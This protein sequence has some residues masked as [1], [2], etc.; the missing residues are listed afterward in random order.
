MVI[1]Q[2]IQLMTRVLIT[3]EL[4]DNYEDIFDNLINTTGLLDKLPERL[5]LAKQ[6][7]GFKET[8]R[9]MITTVVNKCQDVNRTLGHLIGS[10]LSL[11]RR[12]TLVMRDMPLP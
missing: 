10:L 3:D 9:G 8:P 6:I 12:R 11:S 7:K 5:E 4:R 1:D 2:I